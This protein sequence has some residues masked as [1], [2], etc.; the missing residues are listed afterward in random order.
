[1][2]PTPKVK[3]KPMGIAEQRELSKLRVKIAESYNVS[4]KLADR[5]RM[6][7]N[8]AVSEVILCGQYLTRAK[9]IVGHGQWLA[10]LEKNAKGLSKETAQRYMRL[11]KTSH[12]TD[13]T[14]GK[15]LRQAYITAGI[16]DPTNKAKPIDV[17]E[18]AHID[19][20]TPRAKQSATVE[21]RVRGGRGSALPVPAQPEENAHDLILTIQYQALQ[22][23]SSLAKCIKPDDAKHV[24]D[25]IKPIIAWAQ[26]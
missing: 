15:S 2:S 8:A 10:W 5:A 20:P 9:Q 24:R 16:I 21:T 22:L 18:E 17:P 25:F 6:Q 14:N 4:I 26:V 19:E 23:H 7:C 1:M 12:V 11:A 3:S 13:L